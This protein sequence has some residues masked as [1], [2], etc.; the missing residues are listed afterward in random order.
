MKNYIREIEILRAFAILAVVIYHV[1]YFIFYVP[2]YSPLFIYI[3]FIFN[4][5]GYGVPLFIFVSG[6][7]LSLRYNHNN[8]DFSLLQYYKKR[9]LTIIPPYL[10][11][12]IV[13]LPYNMIKYPNYNI[14][15][16]FFDPTSVA[17]HFWFI[18]LIIAY[19]LI[20]PLIRVIIHKFRSRLS[21]VLLTFLII[22]FIFTT[23]AGFFKLP[24][25]LE[26]I[27][28]F[29]LG[30]Y[31]HEN[32]DKIKKIIEN[33]K[34]IL[35]SGFIFIISII[36]QT[37]SD[38]TYLTR[39]IDTTIFI[40]FNHF[41]FICSKSIF[42]IF[43]FVFLF[44]LARFIN[45]KSH[46]IRNMLINLGKYSFGIFLYH[47]LFLLISYDVFLIL[48]FNREYYSFY[49]LYFLTTFL[50]SIVLTYLINLLPF[51]KYVIGTIREDQKQYSLM[52]IEN[53]LQFSEI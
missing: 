11:A 39:R 37:Y 14:L 33:N 44:G 17:S 23:I 10:I 47:Y 12:A 53:D 13:Y 36:L 48:G 5:N 25:F 51:H 21:I 18:G 26:V 20:Y 43:L 30:M 3:F 52:I 24:N 28:Y 38:Y 22:Q 7:V 46:F 45:Q 19:Y 32:Y 49:I 4:L 42:F 27:G 31:V 40:F 8:K 1:T 15:T 9:F 29:F 34:I 16:M 2:N 41:Y 6:F 35:F 50:P